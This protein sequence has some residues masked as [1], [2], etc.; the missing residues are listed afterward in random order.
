MNFQNDSKDEGETVMDT[1]LKKNKKLS[2]SKVSA[3]L[4]EVEP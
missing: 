4:N 2:A 3:Q 1:G